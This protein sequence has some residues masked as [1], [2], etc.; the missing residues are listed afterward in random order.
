[1]H[2]YVL[3]W[4]DVYRL[5]EWIMDIGYAPSSSLF[6]VN[7]WCYYRWLQLLI[8]VFEHIISVLLHQSIGIFFYLIYSMCFLFKNQ[9]HSIVTIKIIDQKKYNLIVKKNPMFCCYCCNNFFAMNMRACFVIRVMSLFHIK[10]QITT[11]NERIPHDTPIPYNHIE[12]VKP[13]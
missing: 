10:W 3:T 12:T 5:H 2:A 9:N 8:Q 11:F 6:H 7:D 4:K 1:M 13:S